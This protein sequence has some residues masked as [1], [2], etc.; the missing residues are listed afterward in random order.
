MGALLPNFNIVERELLIM[1]VQK[2]D[3][4]YNIRRTNSDA[5]QN[6]LGANGVNAEGGK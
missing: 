4:V 3:D 2:L 6:A 5:W 1:L